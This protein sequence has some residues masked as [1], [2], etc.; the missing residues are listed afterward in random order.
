MTIEDAL[1][2]VNRLYLDTAPIIYFV[3]SNSHYLL[4]MK[5]IF[6]MLEEGKFTLVTSPMLI[7]ECLV[8]PCKNVSLQLQQA[9]TD[10]LT[11]GQN[12]ELIALDLWCGKIAAD[13]IARYHLRLAD[14]LHLAAAICA[15]CDA[16]LTNDRKLRCVRE[17]K[18]L[19]L[20]EL[21]I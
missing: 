18:V 2:S 13:L 9:F 12:T 20:Q 14:A 19:M 11:E 6:K 21:T 4:R 8:A 1:I 10:L 5:V 7:A 3:Q 17:L 16:F 15:G